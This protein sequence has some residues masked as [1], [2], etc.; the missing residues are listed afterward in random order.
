[1]DGQAQMP[2]L[3]QGGLVALALHVIQEDVPHTLP[4]VAAP[5]GSN[6]LPAVQLPAHHVGGVD[7]PEVVTHCSPR[8]IVVYFNSPFTAAPPV[9]Q[10]DDGKICRRLRVI[11]GM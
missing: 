5:Q 11:V 10:P 9:H 7:A 1:M 8:A 2:A 4:K 3:A 6:A